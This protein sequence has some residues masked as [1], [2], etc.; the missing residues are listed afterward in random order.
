[1]ALIIPFDSSNPI[2]KFSTTLVTSDGNVQFGFRARWNSRDSA[3][4]MDISDDTGTT[5]ASGIKIV[6]G[7]YLGRQF[8]HAL[9]RDGVIVAVD[10]SGK[11]IDAGIDDLG[12]RV[13]VMQ[14]T[15]ADVLSL[16]VTADFP[17]A[18]VVVA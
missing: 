8:E 16:R 12:T 2:S 10:L 17:D 7:A 6:L 4:Y 11:G 9:F 18:T 15:T 13:Q 5:I 14:L 3:W 1:M